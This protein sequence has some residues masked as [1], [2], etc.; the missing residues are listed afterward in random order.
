MLLVIIAQDKTSKLL[1]APK[2]YGPRC[3]KTC[4]QGFWS[5]KTQTSLLSYSNELKHWNCACSQ[6]SY[7]SITDCD[8]TVWMSLNGE[9]GLHLGFLA[10][11]SIYFRLTL[12][13]RETPKQVLLQTVKHPDECGIMLHFIKVHT[14]W[15]GKKD[16]QTKE[17]NIFF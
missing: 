7:F 14:V 11:W 3:E 17:Y 16:L 4:L 13:I 15:K 10:P 5:S 1:W 2:A 6:F 12:C 9:A 8:Q